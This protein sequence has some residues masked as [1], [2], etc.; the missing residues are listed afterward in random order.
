[1]ARS[2]I[3]RPDDVE[4]E[5]WDECVEMGVLEPV[6]MS[7]WK[8][9]MNGPADGPVTR[10]TNRVAKARQRAV[11][12]FRIRNCVHDVDL[13]G[14]DTETRL[15]VLGYAH[16]WNRVVAPLWRREDDER[17]A[18][19]R[20]EVFDTVL[21]EYVYVDDPVSPTGSR[22]VRQKRFSETERAADGL[23]DAK[24]TPASEFHDMHG[25]DR[26]R[27]FR[28]LNMATENDPLLTENSYLDPNDTATAGD[29]RRFPEHVTEEGD[30]AAE[31]AD[32]LLYQARVW[33]E[34]GCEGFDDLK[35]MTLAWAQEMVPALA[36]YRASFIE[37]SK[38][39]VPL[40]NVD[41]LYG[42]TRE[43]LEREHVETC[44]G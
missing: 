7:H 14:Y 44:T 31:V 37:R 11:D 35:A 6:V 36:A 24:P 29:I 39:P 12:A 27:F 34:Y 28:P 9:G 1:M 23:V 13:T 5:W 33:K 3:R 30:D 20:L 15:A 16:D 8:R 25:L 22:K 2:S 41:A 4:R 43:I 32:N 40:S 38:W 10:M 17:V 42:A 18:R 21:P 19:I 26:A